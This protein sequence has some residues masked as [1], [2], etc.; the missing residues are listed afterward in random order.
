MVR[1]YH[2]KGTNDYLIF[3]LILLAFG[4]WCVKDGWFPSPKVLKKHPREIPAVARIGGT[5]QALRVAPGQEVGSNTVVGVIQGIEVETI[6]QQRILAERK[7]EEALAL[8]KSATPADA[9][10]IRKAEQSLEEARTRREDAERR[11]GMT[12]VLS[13]ASGKVIRVEAAPDRRV[14]E[15]AVV[16]VVYPTEHANFYAFNRVS[17][18]LCA[19]GAIVCFFIHMRER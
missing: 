4:A 19:I 12:D 3:G 13:M 1:K 16:A 11:V 18:F 8:I 5:L 6:H 10:A 2:V 17:A 7:A 9:E 15:G 14:E